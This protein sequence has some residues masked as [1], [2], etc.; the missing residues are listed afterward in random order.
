MRWHM[1]NENYNYYI[2]VVLLH[3]IVSVKKKS[4]SIKK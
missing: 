2:I 1:L 4:Y 3:K